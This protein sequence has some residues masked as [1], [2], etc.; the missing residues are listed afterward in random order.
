MR[1][2]LVHFA[3]ILT[4]STRNCAS[5]HKLL[6]VEALN[7]RRQIGASLT[8]SVGC[9]ILYCVVLHKSLTSERLCG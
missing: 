8:I 7:T 4:N 1:T 5:S 2:L 6:G 3:S 9:F